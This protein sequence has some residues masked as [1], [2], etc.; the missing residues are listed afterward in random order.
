MKTK[1]LLSICTVFCTLF[2]AESIAQTTDTT[3]S[4]VAVIDSVKPATTAN[5]LLKLKKVDLTK[6]YLDQL[7]KMVY[8]LGKTSIKE[9]DVPVNKYT[10]SH[11]N[12]INKAS[13][14]HNAVILKMYTDII[15]YSDREDI[16]Q[17]II[18]FEEIISRMS[19]I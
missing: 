18:F 14:K 6:I 19:G 16:I 11:W 2:Y 8:M 1:T 17:S 4:T 10:D 9:G 12:S 3:V 5:D 7:T 15:P 13:D